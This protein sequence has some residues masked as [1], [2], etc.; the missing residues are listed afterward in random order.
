MKPFISLLFILSLTKVYAEEIVLDIGRISKFFEQ[1]SDG[2]VNRVS[3]SLRQ[4]ESFHQQLQ[5]PKGKASKKLTQKYLKYTYPK[6]SVPIGQIVNSP[7]PNSAKAEIIK[8]NGTSLLIG[9][10][11]QELWSLPSKLLQLIPERSVQVK[12]PTLLAKNIENGLQDFKHN[13]YYS[14]FIRMDDAQGKE[15]L[16]SSPSENNLVAEGLYKIKN[17]FPIAFV[18]HQCQKKKCTTERQN[19]IYS[20]FEF[21]R[22]E[23]SQIL[24][25]AKVIATC[26]Y[27]NIYRREYRDHSSIEVA[28][29]QCHLKSI[30][31]QQPKAIDPLLKRLYNE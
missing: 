17:G 6:G 8:S 15:Y 16:F 11:L 10:T 31:S 13:L 27:E 30:N 12:T 21:D 2:T 29:H 25:T 7:L 9:F 14:T 5:Y 24:P 18:N 1:N 20:S 19:E 26:H 3:F 4:L 22:V 28:Y 23:A